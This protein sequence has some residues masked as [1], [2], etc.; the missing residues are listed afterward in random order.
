MCFPVNG[1]IIEK[2]ISSEEKKNYFVEN[3]NLDV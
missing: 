2:K 1:K 3:S